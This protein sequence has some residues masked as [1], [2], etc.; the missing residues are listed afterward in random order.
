MYIQFSEVPAPESLQLPD[1][2]SLPHLKAQA[3]D[4]LRLGLVPSLSQA[5]FAIARAY[6]FASWPALKLF[7]EQYTLIGRLKHAIDTADYAEARTL[8]T[9]KPEL[10]TARMGYAGNGPLTW[11]AECRVPRVAPSAE[12]LDFARWMMENG[13]DVHQGG[14]GPLM[15][16]ALADERIA[17]M[18]LL[19]ENGADV[20]A[21][22][23]GNYPIILAPCETLA[24]RSLEWLLTHG[25]NPNLSSPEYGTPIAM[26]VYTYCRNIVGR[27]RCIELLIQHGASLPDTLCMAFARGRLDLAE[28]MLTRDPASLNAC[29][30]LDAIYPAEIGNPQHGLAFVPLDGG[31]LL[32]M[33]AEFEDNT[34][35]AFLLE[36]GANPNV[37]AHGK[38]HTALFHTMISASDRTAVRTQMLLDAGADP[39]IRADILVKLEDEPEPMVFEN[40]NAVEFAEAYRHQEW[41]NTAA[42]S[43]LKAA[44]AAR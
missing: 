23:N 22:W 30:P 9:R 28:E 35:L 13:S 44:M 1:S 12:R 5:Q 15:R 4:L 6:G 32:H 18:E 21:L 10:H 42:L 31:T 24:P 25:A 7:V 39:G 2:P 8:L 38:G 16:A 3:S 29:Y 20:N 17:M 36:R 26:V 41:V 27:Q 43:L 40:V 19:V 11:V 34:A 14:D 37:R 33:A